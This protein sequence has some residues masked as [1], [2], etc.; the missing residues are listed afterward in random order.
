MS[1]RRRSKRR[2]TELDE[3]PEI[4]TIAI[5]RTPVR[6]TDASF[7]EFVRRLP[8][9][10]CLKPT[11]GG[12]PCHM[13][14]KRVAGDWLDVDGELVGNI[15]AGCRT[16]HAEQ[17][18]RGIKTFARARGVDLAAVCKLIG[19]AYKRGWSA[20]GLGAAA[21]AARGYASVDVEQ[22]L[23]GELPF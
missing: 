11:L 8:C 19:S 7:R 3:L 21:I 9:V 23:D 1:L 12:D 14:T 5:D 22:V 17:H 6:P 18:D 4:R 10:V 15:Y 13:H 2:Q 20:E 16:H